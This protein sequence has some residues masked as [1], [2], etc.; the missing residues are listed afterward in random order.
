M[1]LNDV[2]ALDHTV[3]SYQYIN[4]FALPLKSAPVKSCIYAC[5]KNFLLKPLA[6]R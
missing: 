3:S 6:V 2:L 5:L 4:L 1:D